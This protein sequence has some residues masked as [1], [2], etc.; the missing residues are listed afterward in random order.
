MPL[1]FLKRSRFSLSL[2]FS[3]LELK[4]NKKNLE[5]KKNKGGELFPKVAKGRF[6]KDLSQKYFQQLISAVGFCHSHGI[7][8][9]NLKLENL[10]LDESGNLKVSNFELSP[11]RSRSDPTGSCTPCAARLLTWLRRFWQ[12]EATM[13]RWSTFGHAASFCTFW[14]RAICRLTILIWWLCTR[15]FTN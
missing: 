11:S 1:K 4:E 7:F 10:L 8:H 6:T 3:F 15:R 13:A 5:K 2:F 12:R 9:R 14:T